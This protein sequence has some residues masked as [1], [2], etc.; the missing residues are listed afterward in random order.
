MGECA[1][2]ELVPIQS[3]NTQKKDAY[4]T[5]N[6]SYSSKYLHQIEI[7][8]DDQN[9][10]IKSLILNN[11][12][13]FSQSQPLEPKLLD[14][15]IIN[16]KE[17]I[18]NRSKE[19]I[20]SKKDFEKI[21]NGDFKIIF[22]GDETI[23]IAKDI[24]DK[25]DKKIK[26]L[27]ERSPSTSK[28]LKDYSIKL[29]DKIHENRIINEVALN[30]IKKI[31]HKN[32]VNKYIA[33]ALLITLVASFFVMS[34]GLGGVISHFTIP[35]M[36]L[37]TGV[38]LLT[39]GSLV[40][41]GAL[42]TLK[43]AAKKNKKANEYLKELILLTRKYFLFSSLNDA[44]S[45]PLLILMGA[46][47]I[48]G[49]IPHLAL[50]SACLALPVALLTIFSGVMQLKETINAFVN[51]KNLQQPKKTDRTL[52]EKTKDFGKILVSKEIIIPSLNMLYITFLF[53][54]GFFYLTNHIDAA[55]VCNSVLGG[56]GLIVAALGIFNVFKQIK[57]IYK[58]NSKN[59]KEVIKYIQD[60]FILTKEEV[61]KIKEKIDVLNIEKTKEY[62]AYKI[63]TFEN[64]DKK[65]RFNEYLEKLENNKV[66]IEEIKQIIINEELALAL[67]KKHMQIL[68]VISIE[69]FKEALKLATTNKVVSSKEIEEKYLKLFL[70]IRKEMNVKLG[71]EF[72]KLFLI[73]FIYATNPVLLKL[74]PMSSYYF[75]MAFSTLMDLLIN[76]KSRFRNV[77]S[78]DKEVDFDI[79]KILL[80][81]NPLEQKKNKNEEQKLKFA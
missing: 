2:I 38:G 71:A 20:L 64:K 44:A 43:I 75:L 9:F 13:I 47:V 57:E 11:N 41:L 69:T 63:K 28:L 35:I 50:I 1:V 52:L 46:A 59:P 40:L 24:N 15:D 29:K 45:I 16:Y 4:S 8:K 30:K 22:T 60:K 79:N 53:I 81:S 21:E 58:I 14:E 74:L 68:S 78:V 55:L 26:F 80:S 5:V 23:L 7:E 39:A 77:P 48:L 66:N 67:D 49:S 56:V 18:L 37:S 32:D 54:G 25:T 36:S 12:L 27:S 62:L 65:I 6:D 76:W 33:H 51:A 31:N 10:K 70:Q 19:Y 34:I 73:Y 72:L 61:K 42:I 3:S 17:K